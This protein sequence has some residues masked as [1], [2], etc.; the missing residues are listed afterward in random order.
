MVYTISFFDLF[1]SSH[2]M[3]SHKTRNPPEQHMKQKYEA[4]DKANET[5]KKKRE[6]ER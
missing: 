6:R 5:K 4:V 1:A 3:K 2:R